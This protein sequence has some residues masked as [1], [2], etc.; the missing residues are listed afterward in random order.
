MKRCNHRPSGLESSSAVAVIIGRAG[1]KGLPGK[2]AM[3][4]PFTGRPAI[5]YSIE[6]AQQAERVRRV[7][8]STDGDRIAEAAI[9]M[10][11]EVVRRPGHLASD[12]ATVDAAVRHAI[13]ECGEAEHAQL[14]VILYANVPVR[15]AGLID[16]AIRTL[17]DSGGHSVQSY[18]Q[19]GKHHPYWMSKLDEDGKVTPNV[20]NAVYRRQD[21]PPLYIPDG[22][23]I[24][25]TRESLFTVDPAQP[26]AFLGTDRR[27]II[28]QPGE[29]IDIDSMIDALVAGAILM[30]AQRAGEVHVATA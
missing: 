15:P 22:G 19:V 28:T 27:G 16:R 9:G 23:V 20:V 5:C 29:V 30:D 3:P 12:T 7:I 8:V 18:C 25:V 17:H 21:L 13:E 14:V 24:V 6:H 10:G 26:H 1:S 2:N 4:L 11:V